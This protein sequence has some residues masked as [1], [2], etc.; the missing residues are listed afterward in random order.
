MA[1]DS[2]LARIRDI[3]AK[4]LG[5]RRQH[6]M[7]RRYTDEMR[8]HIEMAAEANER[9]GMSPDE[10]R[11]A[12]LADFGGKQRWR[13][14]SRDEVRSRPL[15][16]LAQ[17]VRYAVRSLRN[18]PTFTAAAVAT[19]AISVGATTSIFSVVN[20]VLLRGLPYPNAE[21]IVAL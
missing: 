6:D 18:A 21:R 11:R 7:D 12:A 19:L 8:F 3:G 10:A 9:H 4:L 2:F 13:E 17:D 20:T 14:E 16:E 15:E 5:F 1:A